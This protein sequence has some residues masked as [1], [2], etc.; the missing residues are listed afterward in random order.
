LKEAFV[1]VF[2]PI[3]S[4]LL[5]I[6]NTVIDLYIFV[7]IISVVMSWL[8][9]FGVLNTYNANARM[10]VRVIDS[11]TRPVFRPVQR[12]LPPIGGLDLTPLIV[13]IALQVIRML[14]NSYAMML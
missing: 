10:L 7:V 3:L 4:A 1:Q 2:Y 12:I 5:Y 6:F 8:I 13:V 14:V 9:A 11:L